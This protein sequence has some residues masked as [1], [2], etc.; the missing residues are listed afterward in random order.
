LDATVVVN[1][2]KDAGDW[3]GTDWDQAER[4]VGRLRQRIF[5]ASQAGDLKKVRNLQRLMLRSR[6]NALIS[7]RRV[8]E[9]NAGRKTPGIDGKV[10]LMAS[11]KAGLADWC[12]RRFP[13]VDGP[14]GQARAHPEAGISEEESAGNS[15]DRRQG[16]SGHDGERA[17]TRVGGPVRAEELRLPARAR[18]P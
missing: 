15:R 1:G 6:A 3:Y 8:T 12:Q 4:D 17:G 14:A 10:V 16:A 11:Q 9:V 5:A 18:L 2:P 7:V 13:A